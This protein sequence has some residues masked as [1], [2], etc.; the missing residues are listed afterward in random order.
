M[1]PWGPAHPAV[2]ED[3]SVLDEM[4]PIQVHYDGIEVFD[5]QE[6]HCWSFGSALGMGPP[7]DVWFPMALVLEKWIPTPELKRE[8][9]DSMAQLGGYTLK[10]AK[11]GVMADVGFYGEVFAS[12]YRREVAGKK[13][14]GEYRLCF[15]G[16]LGDRKGVVEMSLYDRWYRCICLCEMCDAEKPSNRRM[17]PANPAMNY[18]NF[19]RSAPWRATRTSHEEY[20]RRARTISPWVTHVEGGHLLLAWEDLTHN[21]HL[22]HGRDAS[23]SCIAEML[24]EE[25]LEPGT[26][27]EANLRAL[28]LECRRWCQHH[29]VAAPR[30]R[31]NPAAIGW[32]PS[33]HAATTYPEISS[34]WQACAVRVLITF[35]AVKVEMQNLQHRQGKLRAQCIW[36]LAEFTHCLSI[37]GR[38]LPDDLRRRAGH[39]LQVYL[40]CYQ[41]LAGEALAAQRFMW[42]VRPKHHYLC[43][44]EELVS[45]HGWNPSY[46]QCLKQEDF[47]G[48]VAR[49]AANTHGETVMLRTL[50]RYLVAS[51]AKWHETVQH[52]QLGRW[53]RG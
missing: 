50:E 51:A 24:E 21:V 29:G 17:P 19:S 12:K 41:V 7:L 52:L 16:I 47:C 22:G 28:D 8:L 20:C 34:A 44:L 32:G 46:N 23:G 48:R 35:L 53:G 40:M 15:G 9:H 30:Y 10:W 26:T 13:M 18:G 33:A 5:K 4:I 2:H 43:H 3:A 1:M 27:W 14:A 45:H 31:L 42:K 38:W 37:G 39:A 6:G 36:G 49:L 11:R 25:V